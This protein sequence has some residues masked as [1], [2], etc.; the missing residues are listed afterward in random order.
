M[1]ARIKVIPKTQVRSVPFDGNPV[2]PPHGT[3]GIIVRELETAYCVHVG[4][5]FGYTVPVITPGAA[6]PTTPSLCWAV[7]R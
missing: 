5:I 3:V 2:Q 6:P 1:K 4:G 7:A